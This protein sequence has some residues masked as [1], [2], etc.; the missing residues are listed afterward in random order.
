MRAPPVRRVGSDGDDAAGRNGCYSGNEREGTGAAT[1]R[2]IAR[3]EL[4]AHA[5]V[6][7]VD[8]DAGQTAG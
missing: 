3:A 8:Q 2:I 4:G 7:A 6:F 1:G 5:V